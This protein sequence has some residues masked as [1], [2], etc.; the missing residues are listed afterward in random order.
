MT[1]GWALLKKPCVCISFILFYGSIHQHGDIGPPG[2]WYIALGGTGLTCE[3]D[4]GEGEGGGQHHREH[5]GLVLG[6]EAGQREG[7][8]DEHLHHHCSVC[9]SVRIYK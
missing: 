7:Q 3:G 1:L 9:F 2:S 6:G 4:A 5:P 8:A